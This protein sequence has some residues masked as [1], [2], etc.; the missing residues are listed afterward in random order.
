MGSFHSGKP[1][2]AIK[3]SKVEAALRTKLSSEDN[4]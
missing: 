1:A 3:L 4:I 2:I